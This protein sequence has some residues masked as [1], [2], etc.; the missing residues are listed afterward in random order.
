MGTATEG[1]KN[2]EQ[3]PRC[4]SKVKE[5]QPSTATRDQI[6]AQRSILADFQEPFRKGSFV[7][8]IHEIR[9]V[10]RHFSKREVRAGDDGHAIVHCFEKGNP[11]TLVQ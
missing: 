2:R 7:A 8:A 1:A 6:P 5:R 4:D 9:G 11:E 10:A 3:R